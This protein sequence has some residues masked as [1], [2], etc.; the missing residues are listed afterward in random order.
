MTE[1]WSSEMAWKWYDRQPWMVG[2]NYLPQTAVNTTE[3]WQK[4]TFDEETIARELKIAGEIGFNACRVFVQ[5]L[6]WLHDKEGL[7]QRIDRFLEIASGNGISTLMI[8][9]D[10]CNFAENQAF[11]GMQNPPRPGIHNSQWTSSPN[12]T[13]DREPTSMPL[14][15]EYVK[16]IVTTFRSDER[17]WMWDLFNEPGAS[18]QKGKSDDLLRS[19][20]MWARRCD[21][22]Q[23]LTTSVWMRFN[24]S[25][26]LVAMELSDVNGIHAYDDYDGVAAKVSEMEKSGRPIICTEWLN[27][28][29][30]NDFFKI[31]PYF[32]EKKIASYNWGLFAGKTQT[33]LSWGAANNPALGFPKI[34]QH[35]ILFWDGTPYDA[36]ELEFIKKMIGH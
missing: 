36:D 1:K 11:L 4:E 33:Y 28:A 17:I 21:P 9:F 22:M 23:P 10:D 19:T 5:Y 35:D 29:Y 27:R 31:L 24:I 8:L 2:F 13:T 26:D 20:F 18:D 14:L 6:V 34:W 12:L 15:E 7:K 25:C 32:K 3:M 16:D 30:G